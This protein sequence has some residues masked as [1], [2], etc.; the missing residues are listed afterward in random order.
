[1]WVFSGKERNNGGLASEETSK[2][3]PLD[4]TAVKTHFLCVGII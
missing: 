4:I 1:M 3:V 2:I